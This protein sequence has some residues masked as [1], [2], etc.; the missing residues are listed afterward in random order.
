MSIGSHV[1]D[2]TA[3]AAE[4]R[5]VALAKKDRT[6]LGKTMIFLSSQLD[7]LLLDAIILIFLTISKGVFDGHDG[8]ECAEWLSK[9]FFESFHPEKDNPMHAAFLEA[10]KSCLKKFEFAGACA[11]AAVVDHTRQEVI[12]GNVGDS[13]AMLVEL[14]QTQV[15]VLTRNHRLQDPDELQRVLDAGGW[16]KG[17]RVFDCL[18]PTRTLGDADMKRRGIPPKPL[19]Q[20]ETKRLAREGKTDD[21]KPSGDASRVIIAE[22]FVSSVDL[23]SLGPSILLLGSDGLFDYLEFDE[24]ARL[25][26]KWCCELPMPSC[27]DLAERLCKEASIRRSRD[28]ISALVLFLNRPEQETIKVKEKPKENPKEKEE[29][30]SKGESE[31][32]SPKKNKKRNSKS[33][34]KEDGSEMEPETEA[35]GEGE[36]DKTVATIVAIGA[37][38]LIAAGMLV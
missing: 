19:N 13:H 29:S 30:T 16:V 26:R 10:D 14:D 32:I 17:K 3:H 27:D 1:I 25:L 18:Q 35:K 7:A 8:D 28:D 9:H 38:G 6:K 37:A 23:S 5:I 20:K 24:C 33:K 36:G 22:P 4:D 2:S 12:V 31:L 11:V 15:R 21:R 34:S